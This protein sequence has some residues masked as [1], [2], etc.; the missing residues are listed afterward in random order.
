M[1]CSQTSFGFS[2]W[3]HVHKCFPSSARSPLRHSIFDTVSKFLPLSTLHVERRASKKHHERAVEDSTRSS[4]GVKTRLNLRRVRVHLPVANS[5]SR[6]V[7]SVLESSRAR[8]SLVGNLGWALVPH[9]CKK[10]C[11]V[12]RILIKELVELEAQCV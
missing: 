8:N 11:I 3:G 7:Y 6:A 4:A 2:S 1:L 5:L 10:Y 9:V 12:R